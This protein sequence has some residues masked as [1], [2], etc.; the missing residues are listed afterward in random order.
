MIAFFDVGQFAALIVKAINRGFLAG[1]QNDLV[2]I[3]LGRFLFDEA[4]CR[5]R[6]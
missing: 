2:A 4:Q 3:A 5:Q 6:R 1:L